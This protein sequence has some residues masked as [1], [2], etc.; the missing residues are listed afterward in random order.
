MIQTLKKLLTYAKPWRK[1]LALT[2]FVLIAGA[3]MNL[4]TP[5]VVRRITAVLQSG[6][7]GAQTKILYLAL[8]L[9]VTYVVRGIFRFLAIWQA[10]VAAWSYVPALTLKVYDRI[11]HLSPKWY[12]KNRVGDIMSRVLTDTRNLEI[13]IAHTLPDLLS[14][15]V[16]IVGVSVMLFTINPY[17]AAIT[18]I[19][20]PFVIYAS[21]FYS[22][23]VSPLYKINSRFFGVLSSS[24][25]DRI[26]GM[27]EIQAVSA[28][29]R[30]YKSLA[31]MC[32]TYRK[33]N[34][35]ANFANGIYNPIVEFLT[36]FGTVLVAAI[37]GTLA[38]RGSLTAADIVGFF[39]YL[40]LFYT[41]LTTLAR[42]A[43]DVQTCTASGERVLQLLEEK[44]DIIEKENAVDIGLSKG[45]VAFC[46]VSFGY[47]NTEL[48]N[49]ISFEAKSGEMLAVV[50]ATGAGKTTMVSLMERFYDADSGKIT[51]DGTDISDLTL[52][53][54][55]NN[56]S[57]VLQDVFLFNGTVM[58]NIRYG[59]PYATD[60]EVIKAAKAAHADEFIREM[61]DG[62]NTVVGERG[63]RLSGGQKQRI[64]IARA[65]LRPAPVLILDE[66]T[67]SVDNE[68]EE[69]IRQSI[70]ALSGKKTIIVIAHRLSTV[71]S[72]DKII[73]L[74]N[75][76]ISESGTH[77]ELLKKNGLY[78]RLWLSQQ[79]AIT[80]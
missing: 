31:E 57:V 75:G 4:F 6:G 47:E 67:S 22:K 28:E 58:E 24:M 48:L 45:N 36:S 40:S 19:P 20:V 11:Q 63:T 60:E 10:H 59:A 80:V 29:E 32:K 30:E 77:E 79:D 37:G 76:R 41:P 3:L 49:N 33:I 65:I 56:L 27:K 78:H 13:L 34:I 9:A 54:L 55:R 7:Q 51:L 70:D 72:A 64:A 71:R 74:E 5:A 53:C 16:I 44:S 61:A 12:G 42:L 14:N 62:Y 26:S 8:F 18:L 17:L 23:K 52:A 25:Q 69:M 73:V 1:T 15:L 43:E 21:T 2:V 46:N 66:A 35:H 39:M 68:T 38:L 50:G